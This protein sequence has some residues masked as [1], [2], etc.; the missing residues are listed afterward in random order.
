MIQSYEIRVKTYI[1]HGYLW[2]IHNLWFHNP[3]HSKIV[4]F[5]LVFGVLQ[6]F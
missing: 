2:I 6:D 5:V 3:K 1:V 4:L